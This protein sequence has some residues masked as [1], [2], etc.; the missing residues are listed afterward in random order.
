[1]RHLSASKL[2]ILFLFVLGLGLLA[3]RISFFM[4]KACVF[5]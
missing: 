5:S 1:M 3:I 4:E 2:K